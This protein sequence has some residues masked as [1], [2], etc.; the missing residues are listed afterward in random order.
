MGMESNSMET[1]IGSILKNGKSLRLHIAEM[2]RGH[3]P[4]DRKSLI[5]LAYHRLLFEHHESI[6]LLIKNKLYG[7]SFA[8]VRIFYEIFYRAPWIYG[9]ASEDKINKFFK[10]IDVFP[11]MWVL[12]KEIDTKYETGG[13]W[14]TIKNNSWYSMN[15]YTHSGVMQVVN[16]L[17]EDEIAPNYDLGAVIEVLNG[18]NTVL[19]LM[20]IFFFNVFGKTEEAKKIEKMI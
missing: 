4:K 2:V 12:V 1:K 9:C 5:I 20:S 18:T 8:M 10:G 16:Q 17:K 14:Q 7:S 6:H 11:K 13:F 19:L 3:Y 15:D